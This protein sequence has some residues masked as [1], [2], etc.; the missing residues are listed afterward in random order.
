MIELKLDES[1][2]V[3]GVSAMGVVSK[4]AIQVPFLAFKEKEKPKAINPIRLED[5]SPEVQEYFHAIIINAIQPKKRRHPLGEGEPDPQLFHSMDSI[6][7]RLK[8]KS[9]PRRFKS[10]LD[11]IR[12]RNRSINQTSKL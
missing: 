1:N 12:E 7:N 4:P 9:E 5:A 6:E 8:R 10:R 2:L 3:E 11:L